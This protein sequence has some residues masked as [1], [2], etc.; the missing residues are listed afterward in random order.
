MTDLTERTDWIGE[1]FTSTAGWDLL[2]DLVD[3]G[4]R[5]AGQP[6]ERE[7]LERVRDALAEAGC[8]NA[9]IEEFDL[10]GWVRG[11]SRI[12]APGGEQDCIALPRSP[13]GTATGDLL[14][15]GYGLPEDFENADVEGAVVMVSST[16]PDHYERFI[17]RR[18]KYYYAVQE[19]AAGFVFRNHVEGCLPPTGSVG[20]PGAPI[21][22]IPAVG[23]SAEV[24][25]RLARR[26]EGDEITVE[27][28]C[29]TPD[30]TS[31]NTMA[32][33]GPDTDEEL[34][35]TSHADAHDIAEGAMDN[36]AGTA[37]IVE[38]ANALAANEDALD[39]RVR[40]VAFGA[41]EV[42]LVGS[43]VEADR[44]DRDAVKAIVNVDSNVFGRTLK[45]HTHGFED[46]TA[47]ADRVGERFDHPVATIPEQN[48]HSDHWPFVQ[49]GVPGYMVS[50]KTEGR[51]RG[52][53]HTFADTFE[54]LEVRNL[55][56]Q[57]VLLA[58]LVAD[59]ADDDT[60]VARRDPADIAAAVEA[61][62]LAEGMKVTGD[63]PYDDDGNLAE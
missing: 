39:T 57:A 9:R 11:S 44:T 62:D 31:G 53:G 28:E 22:D 25:A 13:S 4:N 27:V 20:T 50:G 35:V 42:G 49:T 16:V 61:Q 29:E 26:A 37:T 17:H 40:F 6:G 21:G 48:P 60:D 23:V 8:R 18:E 58:A 2:E 38:V 56:E 45:L 5:M 24:G 14:D 12:D 46:L 47:A 41:E 59:L 19:G 15:L 34:L 55:R 7:A 51:G 43:S 36:G 1:T 30:A 32:E 33:L 54:K 63:W 52:W 10:Q 3:I